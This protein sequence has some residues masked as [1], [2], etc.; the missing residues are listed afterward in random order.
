LSKNLHVPAHVYHDSW[1]RLVRGDVWG[2]RLNLIGRP[3]IGIL[4]DG[5]SDLPKIVQVRSASPAQAAGLKPGDM[6]LRIGNDDVKNFGDIKALVG[7]R[8]P[9]DEVVFTV[10]RGDEVLKLAVEIGSERGE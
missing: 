9:G 10:Q 5:R 7:R 6:V 8:N 1:D 2:N 3:V 4:G